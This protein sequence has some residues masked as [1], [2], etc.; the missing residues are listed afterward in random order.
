MQFRLQ[1]Q[2]RYLDNRYIYQHRIYEIAFACVFNF[3]TA[4]V[5]Q[6]YFG[7]NNRLVIIVAQFMPQNINAINGKRFQ[8]FVCILV[9]FSLDNL[10]SVIFAADLQSHILSE[11]HNLLFFK[12]FLKFDGRYLFRAVVLDYCCGKV[13][14]QQL[15]IIRRSDDVVVAFHCHAFYFLV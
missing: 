6:G 1:R 2:K 8:N 3:L 12:G 9:S 4:L 5:N 11:P 7:F 10:N 15:Q 14:A 13:Y